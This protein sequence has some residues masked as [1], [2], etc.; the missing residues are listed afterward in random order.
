M[1]GTSGDV[2]VTACNRLPTACGV[3][4]GP[5]LSAIGVPSTQM[6]L[7]PSL[8]LMTPLITPDGSAGVSEVACGEVER[9]FSSTR[10]SV[11][12]KN[13]VPDSGGNGDTFVG[14]AANATGAGALR[15]L[16][17]PERAYG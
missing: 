5:V 2:V 6:V 17:V 8:R 10:R 15:G 16:A 11:G 12:V 1:R 13:K 7:F 9:L 14:G 3:E 4:A